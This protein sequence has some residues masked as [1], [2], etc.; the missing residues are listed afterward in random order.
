MP[1]WRGRRRVFGGGG[2]RAGVETEPLLSG[3]YGVDYNYY[4]LGHGNPVPLVLLA[5]PGRWPCSLAVD[6]PTCIAAIYRV[7]VLHADGWSHRM[8]MTDESVHCTQCSVRAE[9]PVNRLDF[10][11][12]YTSR[13][14]QSCY[15]IGP[16]A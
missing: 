11:V 7:Y 9:A 10:H 4:S 15:S 13:V 16:R 3:R 14:H 2:G 5:A 8:N 12:R 1:E 6:K